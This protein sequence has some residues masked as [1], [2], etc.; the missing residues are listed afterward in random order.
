[1]IT[2]MLAGLKAASEATGV[3]GEGSAVVKWLR[4]C[5]SHKRRIVVIDDNDG[6]CRVI[7]RVLNNAGYDVVATTDIDQFRL[8]LARKKPF[9]VIS[10]LM[11]AGDGMDILNGL[12]V[13]DPRCHVLLMSGLPHAGMSAVLRYGTALGLNMAG[14]IAKPFRNHELRDIVAGLKEF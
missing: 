5:F 1:M 13:T 10:D 2:I 4:S 3:F 9:L 8:E 7:E 12:A 14:G 6:L 11:L